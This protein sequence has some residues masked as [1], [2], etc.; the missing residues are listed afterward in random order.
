MYQFGYLT[1]N[2]I[3]P[4]GMERVWFTCHPQDFA[5]CFDKLAADILALQNCAVYYHGGEDFLPAEG[6]MDE[7]LDRMRLVVVPVTARLLTEDCRARRELA[8]AAAHHI[9]ILPLMQEPGL[10]TAF[11]EV[12]GNIQFLDP[13][14]E[15]PTALPYEE[16]LKAYLE[17]VLAGERLTT[18]IRDAFDAYIFL[19]YR[20][21]DRQHAQRVMQRIH[22]NDF[23]RSIAIWYDEFLVP[24]E[25]FNLSIGSALDKSTLV[26][27]VVTPCLLEKNAAGEDNYVAR[28][29]YPEA[30]K[31]NKPVLPIEM[32]ETDH[33]G[34]A[35]VY[36]ALPETVAGEDE[37]HLR[38]RLADALEGVPRREETPRRCYLMGL[39][40]LGGI[41]VEVNRARAVELLTTAAENG[42]EDA[43]E[44]LVHMYAEGDGVARDYEAALSWQERYIEI[45][46]RACHQKRTPG[47]V[48]ELGEAYWTAGNLY[49]SMGRY[50]EAAE[51]YDEMAALLEQDKD[52]YVKADL[53]VA[54]S[55]LGGI[56]AHEGDADAARAYFEKALALSKHLAK[57]DKRRELILMNMA[58]VLT[59][60]SLLA[61]CEEDISAARI[62]AEEALAVYQGVD[63]PFGVNTADIQRGIM[64]ARAR[65]GDAAYL[66]RDLDGAERE[67]KLALAAAQVY[68]AYTDIPRAKEWVAEQYCNLAEVT[69]KNGKL[70][71]AEKYYNCAK[72]ICEALLKQEDCLRHRCLLS[73]VLISLGILA[74]ACDKRKKAKGYYE[75]A[76]A[77]TDEVC[78][79]EGAKKRA[80]ASQ[81]LGNA[82]GDAGNYAGA[83]AVFTQAVACLGAYEDRGVWYRRRMA[84]LLM[85]I[86]ECALAMGDRDAARTAAEQSRDR[87]ISVAAE[88]QAPM[89]TRALALCHYQLAQIAEQDGCTED[90]VRALTESHALFETLLEEGEADDLIC[91]EAALVMLALGRHRRDDVMLEAAEEI[92]SELTAA[93]PRE[94]SYAERYRE[95]RTLRGT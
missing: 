14:A 21:K 45:R 1:R 13:T 3:S 85:G 65:L 52:G 55:S 94:H 84:G 64:E 62:Y 19:S 5:A 83:R 44:R 4:Q 41:D 12:L 59:T 89:D 18:E 49:V 2:S 81:R 32:V 30:V 56:A 28:V 16:K 42:C 88:R 47:T 60:L 57:T 7:D 95:V 9:P 61:L 40:Y 51:M 24:G 69:E 53:V 93:H 91:H 6:E 36:T 27:L 25:D 20:K 92:W 54:Y 39:A 77:L 80:I 23:C 37:V 90:M 10:E 35:A 11:N 68:S 46:R 74:D 79:A 86:S 82:M 48:T 75:S 26:A 15:D 31:A 38:A 87:C 33:G 8:Y 17:E 72:E 63:N 67:Y 29:E 70:K 73:D 71:R 34:L 58:S 76:L 78:S 22:D 43:I 66:E 50:H